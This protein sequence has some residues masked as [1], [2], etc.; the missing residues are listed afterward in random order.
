M[1]LNAPQAGCTSALWPWKGKLRSGET[2]TLCSGGLSCPTASS[3]TRD[4]SPLP[5]HLVRM[6][7]SGCWSS[8]RGQCVLAHRRRLAARTLSAR[9]LKTPGSTE[10]GNDASIRVKTS[11]LRPPGGVP[12]VPAGQARRKH[13]RCRESRLEKKKNDDTEVM[14]YTK[15]VGSFATLNIIKAFINY[16]YEASQI[17]SVA[18]YT[19]LS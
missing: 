13:E 1:F 8:P 5:V 17:T 2:R 11:R 4:S 15:G 12:L 10:T 9:S 6:L 18:R 16:C 14:N 7:T 3:A 19:A